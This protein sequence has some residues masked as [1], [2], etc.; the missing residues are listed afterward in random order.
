MRGGVV[1]FDT[2][3]TETLHQS[4]TAKIM[5]RNKSPRSLK[6]ISILYFFVSL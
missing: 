3:G 4:A 6:A 2:K 1:G 5:L